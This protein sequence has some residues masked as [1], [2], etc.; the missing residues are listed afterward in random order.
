MRIGNS[1]GI[2]IPKPVI[3]QCGFEGEVE[4]EVRD[5]LLIISSS[6]RARD[7]WGAAFAR[8]AENGDDQLLDRVA[9][10]ASSWDD[11]EWEW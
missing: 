6:T 5:G 1:R 4:I 11:E 3:E 9:E 8:M 2:R 7:G 10:P